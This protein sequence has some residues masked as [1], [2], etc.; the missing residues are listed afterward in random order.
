MLH[1]VKE[2][3]GAR[4]G[5]LKFGLKRKAEEGRGVLVLLSSQLSRIMNCISELFAT[6]SV[7]W[8]S[9][10]THWKIIFPKDGSV[11]IVASLGSVRA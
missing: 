7:I 5:K 4:Q 8:R 2:D 10:R 9:A 3:K 1:V 11:F 6:W